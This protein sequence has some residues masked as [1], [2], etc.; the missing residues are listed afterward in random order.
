MSD[1]PP[2][3]GVSQRLPPQNLT[4]EQALLG[5]IMA[6]NTAYGMVSTFLLPEHFFDP[7]NARIFDCLGR[8]I[9]AG[10]IANAVTLKNELEN[11]GVLA[12]VG[13]TPYL[14]R[15][16]GSM[17]AINLARDYGWT[18][19]DAWIRRQVI[20]AG[21]TVVNAG[22]GVDPNVSGEDAARLGIEQFI[23]ISRSFKT[24]KRSSLADAVDATL[25]DADAAYKNEGRRGLT[26]GI[27]SLDAIWGGLWPGLDIIGGRASHGK[28]AFGMQII[29]A[30]CGQLAEGESVQFFSLDMP[31]KDIV[32]RMMTT[33]TGASAE[34]I[35]MG[36]IGSIAYQLIQAGQS[37]KKL[38]LDLVDDRDMSV[39]D[40][41]ARA[42]ADIKRL[43]TKLIVIDHLHR[44]KPVAHMARAPKFD[45]VRYDASGLKDM[46]ADLDLPVLVLAQLS[47]DVERR[48][49]HRPRISDIEYLP[50]RECDNI[51]LIWRPE[52]YLGVA[53]VDEDFKS[54]E[55]AQAAKTAFYKRQNFWKGKAEAILAKRRFG[56]TAAVPLDFDGKTFQF[57]EGAT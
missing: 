54:A 15:L 17:V 5:A 35:R 30:V 34:T 3:Y 56:P 43:N 42:R 8:R 44:L 21:E 37:I 38:P 23:E 16:L 55:M 52:L 33:R 31:A 45:Q 41:R 49:D 32:L 26:T 4:A 13:G 18:I 53:P 57:S 27:G 1:E 39:S 14:A 11:S 7:V 51:V 48:P 28:T 19:H 20:K 47:S 6:N 40:I 25:S 46:A 22:F 36:K 24:G 50:E 29:E 9:A 12:A 10:G 2:L